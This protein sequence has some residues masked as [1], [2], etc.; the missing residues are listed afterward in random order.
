MRV[1]INDANILIDI[2]KLDLLSQFSE[3]SYD[4]YTTDFILEEINQEQRLEIDRLIDEGKF[5]IIFTSDIKDFQAI[6]DLLKNA[7]GLSF[8]DCSAWYYTKKMNGTLITG[9]K[10]LRKMVE[11]NGIEV[12]GLIFILD[13]IL[14]QELISFPDAVQKI[15]LLYQLND[16]LPQNELEKR[17]RLWKNNTRL[18]QK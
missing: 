8:E 1:F 9:D 3:L 18:L 12:R 2:V 11:K 10:K 6:N 7:S 16:R 14:N 13:E 17:I 5:N 15:E 4:L